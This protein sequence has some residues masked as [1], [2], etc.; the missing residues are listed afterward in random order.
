MAIC[1][2]RPNLNLETYSKIWGYGLQGLSGV[3]LGAIF[4]L[5]K[6]IDMLYV[7]KMSLRSGSKKTKTPL[8]NIKMVPNRYYRTTIY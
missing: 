8:R 3:M 2:Y 4:I 7:L 5:C 1:Y 6:D